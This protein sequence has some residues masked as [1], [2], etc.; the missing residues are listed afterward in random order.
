VVPEDDR[1][2]KLKH[3]VL[4]LHERGLASPEMEDLNRQLWLVERLAGT[5]KLDTQLLDGLNG[6]LANETMAQL[7]ATELLYAWLDAW[8]AR[9]AAP[10]TDP[11]TEVGHEQELGWPAAP[12]L[13][14]EHPP[15]ASH[16]AA[17]GPGAQDARSGRV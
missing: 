12:Q 3:Q 13:R 14:R 11:E 2:E 15:P 6:R 4:F 7:K 10:A 9:H 8:E 1:F 16:D 17:L 5:G